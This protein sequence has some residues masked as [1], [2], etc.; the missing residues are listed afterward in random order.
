MAHCWKD[1]REHFEDVFGYGTPEYWDAWATTWSED[2]QVSLNA[3]CFLE[4]GHSGP[5]EW[6]PD[7]DITVSFTGNRAD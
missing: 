2:G 5:H 3:T 1:K 7:N 4:D 6:T